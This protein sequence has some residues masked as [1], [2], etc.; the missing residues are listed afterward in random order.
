MFQSLEEFQDAAI[1]KILD[2]MEKRN[3]KFSPKL[4]TKHRASGVSLLE[5]VPEAPTEGFIEQK[6]SER[7]SKIVPLKSSAGKIAYF[8]IIYAL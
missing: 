5:E 7:P 6:K 8:C 1:L 3:R 4:K 2:D